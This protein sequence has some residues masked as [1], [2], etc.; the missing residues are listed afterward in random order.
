MPA[1]A[2]HRAAF[3]RLSVRETPWIKDGPL[4]PRDQLA[5]VLVRGGDGTLYVPP[6]P[7]RLIDG[8]WH[9]VTIGDTFVMVRNVMTVDVIGWLP[10][11]NEGARQ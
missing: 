11:D 8:A 3:R 10:I 1:T 7:C 9:H 6:F 5:A 4:P 2:N